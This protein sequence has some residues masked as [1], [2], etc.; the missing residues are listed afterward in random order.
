MMTNTSHKT[1]KNMSRQPRPRNAEATRTAIL[2]AARTCFSQR[3]YDQVG[4]R[5]IAALAGADAALVCRYFGSKEDLF[6]QLMRRPDEPLEVIAEGREGLSRRVAE[7]VANKAGD[8]TA[9]EDLLIML[10]SASSKTA[11]ELVRNAMEQRFDQPIAELLGGEHANVRARLMGSV[12]IG[13]LV[14]KIIRGPWGLEGDV[15]AGFN[16]RV[17]DL[18]RQSIQEF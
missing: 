14:S 10:R 4:I 17:E 18:I 7:M 8:E 16:E 2:N 6:A 3:S 9:I 1:G 5:E 12:I 11:G 13:L 15:E